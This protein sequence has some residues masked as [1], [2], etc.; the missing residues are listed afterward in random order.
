MPGYVS[1]LFTLDGRVALVTGGSSGIGRHVARTLACAGANVV[2]VGRRAHHLQDAADEIGLEAGRK[3]VILSADLSEREA[4]E[5]VAAESVKPFGDPDIVVNAA[6][7]NLREAAED[8]SWESWQQTLHLNLSVPFMLTRTLV[9]AM[10]RQGLG[11][12][13]N[14]A[15]L[16]SYR[17]FPNGIA[18]GASKGGIAQLTR[19]MAEAW[20]KHGIVS[21]A[22]APGFFPT[23]LTKP[24]F[25]NPDIL[26]HNAAMTAIGRNGEM[27]DLEGAVVLLASRAAAYITG[28]VI[29][30]DGGFSAK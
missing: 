16:Q 22:I 30:I 12:V 8:V 23:E 7:V 1:E 11:N 14:V 24:V 19:A 6:G 29:A 10:R 9:P 18:Y 3:A 25:E 21:N 4:V 20:S 17:A 26:A 27:Q 28:Q 15:S 5:R 2:L 13:I